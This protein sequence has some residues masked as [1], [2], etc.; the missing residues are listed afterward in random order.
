MKRC[1]FCAEEI[2]DE[3]IKC[4]F[5]GSMLTPGVSTVMPGPSGGA[6]SGAIPEV[7]FSYS[8]YRF[9]LGH[10]TDFFGIWDRQAPGPPIKRF[11]RT[12]QGW[13]DA[14]KIFSAWEPHGVS[15]AG[16]PL[17]AQPQQNGM[18]VA[19]LVL[20]IL[21]MIW[22]WGIG[23]LLALI[24]GYQSKRQIDDSG[25]R[26]TGRGLAVAGIATGW[27]GIAEVIVIIAALANP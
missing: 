1:S 16:I 18:A 26:Q 8:G 21:G 27:I 12:D 13:T 10:G 22:L 17:S 3:A 20:G 6:T 14:W 5:C 19:S 4:R 25:G 15:T 24:F 2:R 7:T 23:P 11:A 9:V